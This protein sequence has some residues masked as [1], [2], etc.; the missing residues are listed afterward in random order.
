MSLSDL[1]KDSDGDG[2]TDIEEEKLA[3]NPFDK[4][5]DRDGVD[6]TKDHNPRFKSEIN[7]ET[8]LYKVILQNEIDNDTATLIRDNEIINP[9]RYY[10]LEDDHLFFV[11][12]DDE[13][14]Q[15]AEFDHGRYIILSTSEFELYRKKFPV[16]PYRADVRPKFKVDQ[17]K[18]G[19]FIW[20]ERMPGVDKFLIKRRQNGYEITTYESGI[21]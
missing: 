3:L 14:L 17:L 20:V 19:F 12:S 15:H 13:D 6:D 18:N 16:T 11:V 5:T 8:L 4:D 10:Y 9:G 21:Y 7:N 2:L 1:I